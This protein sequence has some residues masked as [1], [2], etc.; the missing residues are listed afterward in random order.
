[1][2][3]PILVSV[4]QAIFLSQ[5]GQTGRKTDMH[6]E[7]DA[8]DPPIKAYMSAIPPVTLKTSF[9]GTVC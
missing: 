4:A 9:Y 1:M 7:T 6:N 2:W 3:L 5:H 8:T